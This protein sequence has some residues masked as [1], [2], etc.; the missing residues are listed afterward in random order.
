MKFLMTTRYSRRGVEQANAFQI[1]G[2]YESS[3]DL[4]K[5]QTVVLRQGDR[6][7]QFGQEG[8][9]TDQICSKSHL[10]HIPF[11]DARAA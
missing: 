5:M 3:G 2:T 1:L 4:V 7:V 11:R 9:E 10:G 8:V 6:E